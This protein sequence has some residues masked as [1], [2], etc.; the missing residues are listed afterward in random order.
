MKAADI[1][2]MLGVSRAT[3]YRYLAEVSVAMTPSTSRLRKQLAHRQSIGNPGSGNK[4][5]Y[6]TSGGWARCAD[7]GEK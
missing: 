2:K 5:L 6:A 3:V 1:A 4:A 7:G